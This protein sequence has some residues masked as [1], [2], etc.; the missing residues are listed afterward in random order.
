VF[1]GVKF[2]NDYPYALPTYIAGSV[3][4][5]SAVLS[6]FFLNE[7]LARKKPGESNPEPPMSTWQVLKSPGVPTVLYIF[8]HVGLLG[9][10]FTATFPLFMYTSVKRGGFGFS[11][12]RI[13]LFLAIGGGSQALWMLL[14]FPP[15]QKKFGTGF[16][17][18]G[19]AVIWAIF[20]AVYPTLNEFLRN[21]WI[22]A[23]WIIGPI[24]VMLGSGV[25]SK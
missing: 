11:D 16:V 19:C 4:L 12:Q 20:M 22:L 15:L 23:F 10:M 3:V 24:A 6:I 21:G 7:T 25:A 13:A 1:G 14:A 18:R 17:L 2:W 9:L 5:S 8:G